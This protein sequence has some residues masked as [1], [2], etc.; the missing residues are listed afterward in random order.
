MTANL[1]R[2][3][4]PGRHPPAGRRASVVSAQPA[5]PGASPTNDKEA[6][7]DDHAAEPRSDSGAACRELT[8]RGQARAGLTPPSPGNPHYRRFRKRPVEI[9][10]V[11]A[12][13]VILDDDGVPEWIVEAQLKGTILTLPD[14]VVI[15][16]LE[17]TMFAE[18][19]DWIIR[20]VKG[21]LYPCKP[22][23]FEATYEPA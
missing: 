4:D 9:E 2:A 13:V 20:G 8:A 7:I 16:T 1:S 11:P 6:P 17:G 3:G 10:A 12:S 18:P 15:R 23:I 14:K 5:G 21:E 19:D 22:D